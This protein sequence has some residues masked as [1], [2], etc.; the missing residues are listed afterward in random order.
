MKRVALLACFFV[1][2]AMILLS[3]CLSEGREAVAHRSTAESRKIRVTAT[4]GMITDLV[5]RIGGEQ[6]EVSGL[7]GP[8]TDPHLYKA[9]EKDIRLLAGAD[10]VFYNGL[11]LEGKL[12]DV[13]QRLAKRKPVVAVTEYIQER[14]LRSPP[15][16][17]GAHDPHVWFDVAL[18]SRAAERIRDA[19]IELAPR[20]EADFRRRADELLREMADLDAWVKAQIASIP[21]PRRVLITAHDAFGYFGRAYDIEVHGLQGLNTEDEAGVRQVN[22]LVTFIASRGIKAVFVESSV[23]RKNIEALIEGARARGGDLRLGGELYSDA[24]G[25]AGLPEGTYV[26]MVRH[27]VNIIVSAIK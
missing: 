9:R 19:L 12:G 27:N 6:V 2:T 1:V 8:G 4:V 23:P 7:M 25:G 17:A 22:D 21:R 3:G 10:L 14:Q 20:H 15:E 11:H 24:L 16:F 26:G 13:F 18:W 5:Q